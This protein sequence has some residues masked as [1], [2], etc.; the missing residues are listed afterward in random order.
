MGT[1][2][3]APNSGFGRGMSGSVQFPT[4]ALAKRTQRKSRLFFCSVLP[5]RRVTAVGRCGGSIL[6]VISP[7]LLWYACVKLG[8]SFVVLPAAKLPTNEFKD[9]TNSGIAVTSECSEFGAISKCS[10]GNA[11]FS[12]SYQMLVQS[13]IMN[14]S[15]DEST[16]NTG[17]RD[18]LFFV[19]DWVDGIQ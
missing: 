2:Q 16:G 13:I 6:T 18:N 15:S 12:S 4:S 7:V 9:S 19:I 10:S 14:S 3:L 11:A 5:Y 17:S 8:R 1:K